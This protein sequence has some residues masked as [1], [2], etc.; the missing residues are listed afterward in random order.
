MLT[1][2]I[3]SYD[4]TFETVRILTF[5]DW[6]VLKKIRDK[7][8]KKGHFFVIINIMPQIKTNELNLY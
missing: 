3:T 1:H 7:S 4:Y 8:D 2:F 5:T 6:L